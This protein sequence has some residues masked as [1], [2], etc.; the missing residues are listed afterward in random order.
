MLWQGPESKK[1]WVRSLLATAVCI[2]LFQQFSLDNILTPCLTGLA[3][4]Q[5]PAQETGLM[6]H[7]SGWIEPTTVYDHYA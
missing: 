1:L 4:L 5:V 7:A 3:L 6:M 2:G